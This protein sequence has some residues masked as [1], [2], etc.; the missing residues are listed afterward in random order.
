MLAGL[1][2][3]R[4]NRSKHIHKVTS[5]ILKS[6]SYTDGFNFDRRTTSQKS[7]NEL[8][9][10]VRVGARRL[11]DGLLTALVF[12]YFLIFFCM[13]EELDAGAEFSIIEYGR[14]R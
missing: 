5:S 13:M 9:V 8:T 4:A 6:S 11:T 10:G 12:F 3:W 7:L 1:L 2:A 14:T